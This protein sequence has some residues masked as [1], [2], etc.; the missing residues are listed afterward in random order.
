M[1]YVKLL[2]RNVWWYRAGSKKES[3]GSELLVLDAI[4]RGLQFQKF[5][6]DAALKVWWSSSPEILRVHIV[7]TKEK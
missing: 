1:L 4:R 2:Q 7:S 5:I 3:R 6:A